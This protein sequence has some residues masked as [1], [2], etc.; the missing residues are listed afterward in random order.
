MK[1]PNRSIASWGL[2]YV[3][4]LPNVQVVL[5]GMSAM[6]QL[7]DNLRTFT[8]FTPLTDVERET[9]AAALAEYK[10]TG[11]VPC[12]GCRY[13]R[14]CP[15]GVDIPRNLALY[16]QV[17]AQ[18][19]TGHAGMVYHAMKESERASNCIGC[20][21][22]KTRCPQKIDIPARLKDTAGIFAESEQ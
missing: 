1:N 22:C 7:E 6:D 21:V 11:A 17:K 19:R 15:Q 2:R 3:A 4:S 12:T 16:N 20:E 5:S 9:V 18:N 14:P 13:C 8:N 10:K